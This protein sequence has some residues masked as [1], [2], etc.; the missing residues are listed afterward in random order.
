MMTVTTQDGR[1]LQ[2]SRK[3]HLH[4]SG[5]V[6]AGGKC[7]GK[8]FKLTATTFNKVI[9]HFRDGSPYETGDG[10]VERCGIIGEFDTRTCQLKAWKALE[11]AWKNGD[12]EF[13]V[14]ADTG[15]FDSAEAFDKFCEEH[16]LTCVLI[17]ELGYNAQDT[18]R[19]AF[20]WR[21]SDDFERRNILVA[22]IDNCCNPDDFG[23]A[24]STSLKKWQALHSA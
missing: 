20:I 15:E 21:T 23:G 2:I 11:D 1:K 19:N 12:S 10:V 18:A 24:Y 5:T 8:V 7:V 9:C 16:N 13:T 17:N 3:Y 4:V 6:H 14:P 22:D